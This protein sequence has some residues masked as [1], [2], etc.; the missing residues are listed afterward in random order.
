MKH[1]ENSVK[2]LEEG[3]IKILTIMEERFPKK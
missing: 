1:I 3:Q 2:S